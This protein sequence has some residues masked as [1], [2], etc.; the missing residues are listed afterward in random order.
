M[1]VEARPRRNERVL[2]NTVDGSSVLLAPD[3]GEY[4]E[5]EDVGD[6]IWQLADG[7]RTVAEIVAVLAEQFDAP[8]DTIE[9][10]TIEL[11]DDLA[12]ENLILLED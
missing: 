11:L 8:Q 2:F 5:L 1:D 9:Q 12:A 6:H 10:D 3:T 7:R 4:F